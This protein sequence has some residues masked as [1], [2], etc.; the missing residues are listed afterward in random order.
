MS[1]PE[2]G[3][4][5]LARVAQ[6]KRMQLQQ[7]Q[8][9]IIGMAAEIYMRNVNLN[10]STIQSEELAEKCLESAIAFH[11][12]LKKASEKRKQPNV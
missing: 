9:Q 2:F 8:G 11:E 12:G 6:A 5:D 4:V 1:Q 10:S 3:A 7:I